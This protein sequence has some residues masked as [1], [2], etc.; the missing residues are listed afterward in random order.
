MAGTTTN[1]SKIARPV[2]EGHRPSGQKGYQP[3]PGQRLDPMKLQ[4]PRGGSA[5]Q[6]PPNGNGA[7]KSGS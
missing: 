1:Q 7:A 5:V 4:P 6:P 2:R 3:H